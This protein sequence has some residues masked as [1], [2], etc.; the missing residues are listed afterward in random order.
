MRRVNSTLSDGRSRLNTFTS[1]LAADRCLTSCQ[2]F[3]KRSV[4][5]RISSAQASITN[6]IE[7]SLLTGAGQRESPGQCPGVFLLVKTQLSNVCFWHLADNSAA[8]TLVRFWTKADNAGFRPGGG[9][10][11]NDPK[12]TLLPLRPIA[13]QSA[14]AAPSKNYYG[15]SSYDQNNQRCLCSGPRVVISTGDA[16]YAYPTTGKH[17]HASRGRMRSGQDTS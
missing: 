16:A 10:S 6:S 2:A 4:S 13:R 12:R 9:L 15:G 5:P 3:R 14:S 1:I 11:A 7:P 8:P 17:D